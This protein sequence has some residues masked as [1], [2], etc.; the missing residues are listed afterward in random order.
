LQVPLKDSL[1]E[2]ALAVV[3]FAKFDKPAH[4][5]IGMRSIDAFAQN[6]SRLPAPWNTKDA[7]EVLQTARQ[8]NNN[9]VAPLDVCTPPFIPNL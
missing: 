8:I 4:M 7:E 2:P 5:H 3:D 1:M 6:N 9:K